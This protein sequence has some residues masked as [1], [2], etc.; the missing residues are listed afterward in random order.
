MTDW[1][2]RN[3]AIIAQQHIAY[4]AWCNAQRTFAPHP[5]AK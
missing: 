1:Q 5:H 2:K 4:I 3:A